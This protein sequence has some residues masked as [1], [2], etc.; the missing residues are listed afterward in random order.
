MRNYYF[1][2]PFLLFFFSSFF[3]IFFF[4]AYSVHS[5]DLGRYIGV[6]GVGSFV[7]PKVEG[8]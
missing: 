1:S 2:S 7:F 3:P 5:F 4:I 6:G 8:H